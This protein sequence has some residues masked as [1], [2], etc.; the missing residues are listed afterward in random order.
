MQKILEMQDPNSCWNK[1]GEDEPV[2]V[3][4]AKDPIARHVIL[5]WAALA[6]DFHSVEKR[7]Q[8][9]NCAKTFETWRM[10]QP[11]G[12]IN[13]SPVSEKG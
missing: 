7:A 6:Q 11:R 4:R 8:A 1:A 10:M 13:A 12:E 5:I 3:L 2:F 9:I